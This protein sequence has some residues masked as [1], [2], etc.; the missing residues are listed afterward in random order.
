M[1]GG[2]PAPYHVLRPGR[3]L[4]DHGPMTLTIDAA[5]AGQPLTAAAVAGAERALAALA[6][7]VPFLP[8]AR[9]EMASLGPLPR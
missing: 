1:Q 6:E 9:L 7:L 2:D 3:V 5:A 4:V 8:V